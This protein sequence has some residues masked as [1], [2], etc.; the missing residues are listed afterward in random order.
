M[1]D[2][3]RLDRV[4]SKF[5][6]K[7]RRGDNQFDVL[8]PVHGDKRSSAGVRL[9]PSGAILI[10]C[11]A[12]CSTEDI[13][14]A[15]GI[16]WKDLFSEDDDSFDKEDR[17]PVATYVYT[18]VDGTQLFRVQ[19]F[20][21]QY[22]KKSFQQQA[23]DGKGGWLPNLGSITKVPY[24][25]PEVHKAGQAE[26]RVIIVEGEKDVET[27]RRHG[28]VASTTPGGS[29]GWRA[30]YA[31]FF[32]GAEVIVLPDND[33]PGKK[34]AKSICA[35]LKNAKVIDLP[36]LGEKEDI[37]DWLLTHKPEE[38][39]LLLGPESVEMNPCDWGEFQKETDKIR[40]LCGDILA[41]QTVNIMVADAGLG[42][43]GSIDTKLLTRHGWI[44][45]GDVRVGDRIIGGTSGSEVDVV[46]VYPRGI[47]EMFRVTFLDG[48]SVLCDGDH[49]WTVSKRT[50]GGRN[51]EWYTT[52]TRTIASEHNESESNPFAI[53]HTP[54]VCDLGDNW[55]PVLDPYLLGTYLGD[56]NSSATGSVTV[57]DN[58][59]DV[60]LMWKSLAPATDEI[61]MI[62]GGNVGFRVTS[63][64]E[65]KR[66]ATA[67]AL[68]ALGL[69]GKRSWEKSIPNRYLYSR[70]QD[71][72]YLLAGLIDTDGSVGANNIEYSSASK[73]LTDGVV[74]LARSLGMRAT[75]PRVSGASYFKDGERHVCRDRYRTVI[76]IPEGV[77]AP[78]C[79]TYNMSRVSCMT[80][81]RNTRG[82]RIVS[83]EP[84]GP[85]ECVCIKVDDPGELY[86]TDGLLVTHNTT[87]L[88]Q[89]CLSLASGRPFLGI[90]VKEPI[91]VLLL[92]AEGARPIFRERAELCR[93]AMGIDPSQLKRW[94]IQ[95]KDLDDF[96]L[97]HVT[98]ERQIRMS[99]AK[100]VIL[101][102][103]GYFLL[104]G[105]ENSSKD[106]K[107]YVMEPLRYLKRKYDCAFTLI[108]H[109]GKP[110]EG[111]VGHHRG[112]GTSAMFGDCD[113]WM[114]LERRNFTDD[115]MV[116]IKD[117][118][119]PN[120]YDSVMRE[121]RLV[122]S[123]S[124]V[125][126]FPAPIVLDFD[127]EN[128]VFNTKLAPEK[129]DLLAGRRRQPGSPP[130][131][132]VR[133]DPDDPFGA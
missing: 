66:S 58:D 23:A 15:A 92:E 73:D 101:D 109:E 95:S 32:K 24:N 60:L 123:K 12:G 80:R 79:T 67:R 57:A 1:S 21:D 38:L 74:F 70:E 132:P 49:L 118:Y 75:E 99:G 120:V 14:S 63:G 30:A 89:M 117:I 105:D 96:R 112:R 82:R 4:L 61:V 42:K 41:A 48:A 88:A 102:T 56:G 104:P 20:R 94:F 39:R 10:H 45:M 106:W 103:L 65:R 9:A 97:S 54:T 18:D 128:A 51:S 33:A 114:S 78:T 69:T 5:E 53:P 81:A 46:G 87:L 25:L 127:F 107:E 2:A 7:K 8:C 129:I 16:D 40:Y 27:L 85:M 19:K 35:D 98:L 131:K 83:V 86:L 133:V 126:R 44:R 71:R 28:I 111:K 93:K 122:W 121:R 100:F 34:Y 68:D 113:T 43:G 77:S 36:G 108:H 26:R 11:L 124:K 47:Q 50:D 119:G 52:D 76:T 55:H 84:V 29:G 6:V 22:G 115:D 59:P 37:S 3:S 62:G 90:D 72:F 13:I 130:P 125:G 64:G 116:L 91:P 110:A 17:L 31:D